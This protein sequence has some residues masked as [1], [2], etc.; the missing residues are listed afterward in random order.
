MQGLPAKVFR[1]G[2]YQGENSLLL[3]IHISIH[4]AVT[5]NADVNWTICLKGHNLFH[6]NNLFFFKRIRQCWNFLLFKAKTVS[7]H[8][9]C[10]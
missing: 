4:S 8:T 6:F 7:M 3:G 9:N 1:W 5:F 2:T 10:I